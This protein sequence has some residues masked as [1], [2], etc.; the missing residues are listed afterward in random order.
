MPRYS[1]C[2]IEGPN[3]TLKSSQHDVVEATS[4]QEALATHTLWPVVEN[5]NHTMACA[6]N[7]GTCMYY[8]EMWEAKTVNED[9]G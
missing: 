5:Y 2:Y 1:L 6:Q 8:Q 3:D 7:P 4:F 9:V